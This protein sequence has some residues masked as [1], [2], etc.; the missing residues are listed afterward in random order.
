VPADTRISDPPRVDTHLKKFLQHDG[1]V[2]RFFGIWDDSASKFGGLHHITLLYFLSDETMELRNHVKIGN[3]TTEPTFLRRGR[4]P[5][6]LPEVKMDGSTLS[7]AHAKFNVNEYYCDKDLKIGSAINIYGR[8]IA[9]LDCDDFTKQYFNEKYGQPVG[10]PIEFDQYD[11]AQD[12]R[13]VL[14][15]AK[16]IA[17][18]KQ[19]AVEVEEATIVPTGN[20]PK[21]KRYG[22]DESVVLRFIARLK[23]P[24]TP[25]D[26]ER[27]FVIQYHHI[28]DTF[29]VFEK[30]LLNSGVPSGKFLERSH[31]K[32]AGTAEYL[33]AQDIAVHGDLTLFS[34]TFVLTE[35]DIYSVKY[36]AAHPDV[37][38]KQS[39]SAQ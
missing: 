2:L 27:S 26:A 21:I 7:Q 5:R 25:L 13:V 4:V 18:K 34:R 32:K 12:G 14:R 38:T 30:P 31:V 17:A 24:A 28:D 6:K 20:T 37:F 29:A 39:G 19:H 8:S 23:S 1:H 9:L 15:P 3:L 10:E 16:K 35:A 33:G 11:H 22:V 36:M